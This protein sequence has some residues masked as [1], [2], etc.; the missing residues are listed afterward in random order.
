MVNELTGRGAESR[1]IGDL[2]DD[3]DGKPTA[4]VIEG[5][6]GIGKTT[7][8]LAAVHRARS[9][10]IRV[11]TARTSE[12]ESVLAYATLADL[13][14][15]V[16]PDLW[17]N[18]PAP[19]RH[20][21]AS[22]L[23]IEHTADTSAVD[24]RAVGAAFLAV[25]DLIAADTPVLLAIDDVQWLDASSAA[26]VA[27]VE[28]RLTARISL[29]CTAR[30]GLDVPATD[31]FALQNPDAVQ[32]IRLSPLTLTELHEI[33]V[34]RLGLRVGRPVMRR[35]HEISGGNPFYA[36]E[37]ARE[38]DRQGA[39]AEVT[40]PDSLG[41]LARLRVNN[42]GERAREALLALATLA[43]PTV[44]DVARAVGVTPEELA[45]LLAECEA[46]SIV[47]FDG[48]RVCF[49]HP[50]LAHAVH[51]D[52]PAPRRRA[53]HRRLSG[54]VGEPELRARHL[55]LS[56]PAGTPATLQALDSAART[57]RGR[58]A[59]AA[60]AE[61][62]TMAINLG[63]A[64]D[65]RR[66][67]LAE[68]LF[69][70][71]DPVLARET[72]ETAI[73]QL[74]SGLLRAEALQTLA[75]VRLYDDSFADAAEMGRRALADCV[76]DSALRVDIVSG[77]AFAS[78]NMGGIDEALVL[79]DEAVSIA[80]RLELSE[81]LGRALGMRAMLTFMSGGGVAVDDVRR[82][83]ELGNPH[84]RV[85]VAFRPNVQ[86]L[87]LLGWTG[88]FAAA[89]EE[90][91]AVGRRCIALGEEGEMMFIAFQLVLFDVWRGD[92]GSAVATADDALARARQLGGDAPMSVALTVQATVAV[93]LGR[94]DDARRDLAAALD[95][96]V[97]TGHLRI[98]QWVIAMLCFLEL[99]L[100]NHA[101]AVT[102]A[103]PLMPMLQFM[104]DYTEM[105]GGT[106]I[107]DT[108]E[109]MIGL[110]S[111]DQAEPLIE[112][113]ERNGQRLDRAWMLAA[114]CRCR[115]MLLAARGDLAAAADR[116][117]ASLEYNERVDMPFERARTLLLIGRLQ[118]RLRRT[119]SAQ[120]TLAEALEIFER[121][122]ARLWADQTRIEL[123]R[124]AGRPR[125]PGLT[126]TEQ[127]VADLAVAGAT[128]H[129]IASTLFITRKTVE[130]NLSRVYRKL[131]VHSRVELYQV[132][133]DGKR[134]DSAPTNSQ[135]EV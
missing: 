51:A 6:A 62:L 128:N 124:R 111:V 75:L 64:S 112:A 105:L 35:I 45:V 67:N 70:A 92:F 123:A 41:T 73:A 22:A 12:A 18:L 8:W 97:R 19:Q 121:L 127:R 50:L 7:L 46:Q 66:I 57:A 82:A 33:L 58:G 23:L 87:L 31:R 17:A 71:G 55:A 44:G 126:P 120:A 72:L 10:G 98:S 24:Q 117:Q 40:L 13:M 132:M 39:A 4:L 5:D 93:Y 90:L 52:A 118:R 48:N 122:G 34:A 113:L 85:P 86:R 69:D 106:F 102:A 29:L 88:K 59:P 63:G 119:S 80:E 134:I 54:I 94:V 49:T 125:V 42:V 110:G 95:A 114:A 1:R 61:L 84:A 53:M 131:G 74:P 16:D 38:I 79:G 133:N 3:I 60:A 77:L 81:P 25:L 107:P 135:P 76:G 109:A 65:R 83:V 91:A 21:L 99:S 108:A 68:C 14:C 2:L 103:E 32:R 47:T 11:L 37:L 100:G 30:T 36:I 20:G 89:R 104:P 96:A 78:L 15:D 116:A 43:T 115:A 101:N 26:V 28:R 9:R 129:A 27:F 56:D 130:V